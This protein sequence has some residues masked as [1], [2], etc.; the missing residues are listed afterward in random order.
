MINN[1]NDLNVLKEEPEKPGGS[2]GSQY[3]ETPRDARALPTGE[4]RLVLSAEQKA[5]LRTRTSRGLIRAVVAQCV[6]A[7]LAT[8]VAW[9]V[10]GTAAGL[11]ALVGAGA[12]LVPNTLFALRLL[13]DA[14]RPGRANPFTFFLG[15][16]FKLGMT[17]LLL[18]LAVHLG[19]ERIVWP[20]MLI[21]L[22]CALK[23][24]VLLLMFGKLS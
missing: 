5:A 24:Y 6:M 15:E 10:A 21:G 14:Q 18:W 9:L 1:S 7:V 17:V 11:S 19:G 4:A 13:V 22:I 12:Y 20:A 2:Q 8:V 23:G 3:S 16:A